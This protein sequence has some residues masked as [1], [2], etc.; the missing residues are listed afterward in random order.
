MIVADKV[1]HVRLA[2]A[3]GVHTFRIRP[4]TGSISETWAGLVDPALHLHDRDHAILTRLSAGGWGAD[5]VIRPIRAGLAGG[6][7][8][9]APHD[10]IANLRPLDRAA[11]DNLVR[12]H[13][14]DRPLAR[15]IEMAQIVMIAVVHGVHADLAD[16]G[17]TAEALFEAIAVKVAED[18]A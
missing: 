9:L 1:P 6:G 13:V 4:P 17:L 7:S 15:S 8:L 11:L 2:W 10:R 3:G 12:K 5:D 16:E 14:E 18:A